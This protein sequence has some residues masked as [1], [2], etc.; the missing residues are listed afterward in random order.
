[1]ETA[2]DGRRFRNC[3]LPNP[4]RYGQIGTTSAQ[5]PQKWGGDNDAV[6]CSGCDDAG[7]AVRRAGSS[8]CAGFP[9][10]DHHRDRAVRGGRSGRHHR[11]HRRRH[12]H[13]PSRR[14]CG[15][16]ECRRRGRH[17]RRATRGAR[18]ARWLHIIVGPHGHQR[19]GAD[20]LSE[21]RLR[22][23][24]GFRAD[25]P[26]RGISGSAGGAE[27]FPRQQPQGIHRLRQGE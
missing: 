23:A 21:P 9:E 24:E 1:M 16:R 27:G 2:P 10:P 14:Q 13:A 17:D 8:F 11:P 5:A 22:P 15:G 3:N 4:H 18:H 20:V 12:P 19:R 7:R 6:D 26:D 25:Q